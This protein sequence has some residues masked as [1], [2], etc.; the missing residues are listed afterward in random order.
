[1]EEQLITQ[2]QEEL[3]EIER[4]RKLD[5]AERVMTEAEKYLRNAQNEKNEFPE[6]EL[7]VESDIKNHQNERKEMIVDV[8]VVNSDSE[9]EEE[10]LSASSESEEDLSA[11]SESEEEEERSDNSCLGYISMFAAMFIGVFSFF[12]FYPPK[13]NAESLWITFADNCCSVFYNATRCVL[14]ITCK[15]QLDLWIYAMNN[16]VNYLNNCCYIY[17]P[18]DAWLLFAERYCDPFCLRP[19]LF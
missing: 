12:V 15:S 9:E 4:L 10:D 5:E 1:M 19:K 6:T 3:E 11:S 18:Y 14:N 2:A 17:A 8:I 7:E 16:T 13:Y